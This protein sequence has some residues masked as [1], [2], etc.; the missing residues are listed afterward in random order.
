MIGEVLGNYRITAEIGAGGMGSVFLAEH[1]LIGRQA[2]IKILL[3]EFSSNKQITDRF[4]DEARA[5]TAIRHPGIVEI[6]D[7]GYFRDKQAYIVME[8]LD[9]DSLQA[10]LRR[11]GILPADRALTR[12]RQIAGA[13]AAAHDLDI[14]HRD[15]K[16]GNIF[17]VPD[18]DIRSGERIK[19]LDFGIAKL[20]DDRRT[21]QLK[22]RTGVIMGTPSYMAPEQ[23]KGAGRVDHR[24]DLYSLGCILFRMLCGRAPFVAEGGGEILAQQIYAPPPVPSTL[25]ADLP[26]ELDRFILH[27]LAKEPGDRVSSARDAIAAIDALLAGSGRASQLLAPASQ[28]TQLERRAEPKR[29]ASVPPVPEQRPSA[30]PVQERLPSAP[31]VPGQ[32]PGA[33]PVQTTLSAGARPMASVRPRSA[34]HYVIPMAAVATVV[35]AVGLYAIAFQNGPVSGSVPSETPTG[36][37]TDVPAGVPTLEPASSVRADAPVPAVSPV[38]AAPD[39]GVQPAVAGPAVPGVDAGLAPVATSGRQERDSPAPAATATSGPE[40]KNAERRKPAAKTTRARKKKKPKTRS[41]KKKL[42]EDD[43]FD[44]W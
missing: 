11:L 31:P 24:A 34:R 18:P 39:A 17:V 14:V 36:P 21:G 43:V 25:C 15:L 8:Y 42:G 44:E 23:C 29:P 4:F 19:L 35:V 10:R 37:S 26:A 6:F 13:L 40:Q 2:A 30:P 33:T 41:T 32:A 38:S 20:A 7:F 3:P 1:V 5:T 27:L 28:Y 9:G 16:P 22:T 12:I